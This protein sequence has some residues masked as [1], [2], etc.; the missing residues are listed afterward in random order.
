MEILGINADRLYV[1]YF[2]GI[3]KLGLPED[4]E[5]RE[6]WKRIG[7]SSNRILPF[8]AENFWEM[9]A[10]G[11]CGPCTEIHYDR[12]GGRDASRLVNID[13]SVVEIW[14]IVF[15]S[16]V[17]DSCGQIR[18][19]GKN[20]IDTGMGF[21]RLLSVVQNKTS[22]FDTD[23][24]TPILEKTSEL[25]K[26]QYTGSLDSRQD[27]TFRLVADHI[28]AATVAISDGAVPDGTGCGFIVRKMMRRAFL[29]GI[30]KLGIERYAMSELVPVVASTMVS[31]KLLK[32]FSHEIKFIIF[33]KEVYPEIHD[34]S[35]HIRK[36]FN[37]EEAQFWKT[38][39]KAKKMFDSV[40]AES[41]SPII[42][43]R[44]AFNLFETHGLPLAV[45]VELA[46]NIGR[47]VDETEF[48]RC[49]LEAQKVSQKASQFKLPISADDFPSHSDKEKYS[50]VF[51][52]G[53]Y[54]QLEQKSKK[55]RKFSVKASKNQK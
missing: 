16:S 6:I 33:Q 52:N 27:A 24:F 5:C 51:R 36:I 34:T 21:E 1:S 31:L 12:I 49:R 15:M 25:A 32:H 42:S 8:V 30:S 2:G 22:N 35:T 18:H 45:T 11:P 14:N 50:Y 10:A 19:L 7:V 3:E 17:R 20:H 54:G 44:K 48:E 41:K 37:D 47:E 29:Q 53:K 55:M 4:R 23:V 46:R 9:G 28:R 38:V 26:K 13:D 39:D 40:A 43:G